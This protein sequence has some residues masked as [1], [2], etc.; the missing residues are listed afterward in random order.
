MLPPQR[1]LLNLR[2]KWGLC[3]V[4]AC[5]SFAMQAQIP[6]PYATDFDQGLPT[7]WTS[8]NFWRTNPHNGTSN[9]GDME[10][11][12]H[13]LILSES[14][15]TTPS[16]D[17]TNADHP[18]LQ[19][20]LMIG[21]FSDGISSFS[22]HADTGNGWEPL[23]NCSSD[24]ILLAL[25]YPTA[26]Q[27]RMPEY[28]FSMTD[29]STWK[30]SPQTPYKGITIYLEALKSQKQVQ[31]KFHAR[32]YYGGLVFLDNVHFSDLLL[33][34]IKEENELPAVGIYPNPA[35]TTIHIESSRPMTE[36]SLLNM[37]GITVYS[38]S[39]PALK[40]QIDTR[41]FPRGLYL[42]Q[43]RTEGNETLRQKRIALY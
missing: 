4:C 41:V 2:L 21:R 10:A 18:I 39:N 29:T 36:L 19:F 6:L 9:T 14:N 27:E 12:D 23:Y 15:L 13:T 30:P 31:F 32:F 24:S 16:F 33:G 5:F 43:W 3:F 38:T 42:L 20:S 34:G 26:I 37:Q 25:Q 40:E 22:V 28:I 11:K 7:G 1:I 35:S 8:D 17:L